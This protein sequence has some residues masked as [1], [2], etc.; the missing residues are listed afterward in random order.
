MTAKQLCPGVTPHEKSGRIF[1]CLGNHSSPLAS[2]QLYILELSI[3]CLGSY[4]HLPFSSTPKNIYFPGQSWRNFELAISSLICFLVRVQGQVS[5]SDLH[6]FSHCYSSR[7][8]GILSRHPF[9]LRLEDPLGR[10]QCSSQ[11]NT[12]SLA[13]LIADFFI[14]NVQSQA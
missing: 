2:G 6:S 10:N 9:V 4:P 5:I 1:L 3:I 11:G 14:L 12:C 8:M 13:G 7:L